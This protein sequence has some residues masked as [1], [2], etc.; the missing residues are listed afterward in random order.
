[1]KGGTYMFHTTEKKV[2]RKSKARLTLKEI[3][4]YVLSY[5]KLPMEARII[6]MNYIGNSFYFHIKIGMQNVNSRVNASDLVR[7]IN[8]L[9]P[10]EYKKYNGPMDFY[11][12]Y[13]KDLLEFYRKEIL[14]RYG[15]DITKYN[16]VTT[17]GDEILLEHDQEYLMVNQKDYRGYQNTLKKI[18]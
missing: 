4:N 13:Y 1:M 17:S 2:G 8:I 3:N 5:L 6:D 10:I 14:K 15:E 11:R 7:Y 9:S 16:Y 12:E 18:K